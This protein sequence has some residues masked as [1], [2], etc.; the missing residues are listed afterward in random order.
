MPYASIFFFWL[1]LH[2][3]QKWLRC[4][5]THDPRLWSWRVCSHRE[6]AV[7]FYYKQGG[8]HSTIIQDCKFAVFVSQIHHW[9]TSMRKCENRFLQLLECSFE[10]WLVMGGHKWPHILT[11][12]LCNRSN[13]TLFRNWV[14]ILNTKACVILN[15]AGTRWIGEK[16]KNILLKHFP[17]QS[18]MMVIPN[19]ESLVS[20]KHNP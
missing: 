15:L 2:M 6:L 12:T 17:A 14:K 9:L 13:W 5:A 11:Q 7:A 18:K 3:Y 1:R 4:V 20:C 16:K 19:L 10:I 8:Q